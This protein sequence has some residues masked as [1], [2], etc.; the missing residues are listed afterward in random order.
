V[1]AT[2][3]SSDD[4][5]KAVAGPRSAEAE[6]AG[7]LGSS[8]WVA[9]TYFAQGLPYSLV[10]Q[11]A[12]QFFT[13]LGVPL[14]QIGLTSL[15]GLAWNLKFAWSPVVDRTSTPRRW[16]IGMQLALGAAVLGL[17]WPAARG[18]VGAVAWGLVVLAVLA[19]THDVAIDGFYLRALGKAQQASLSGLRV[20]AYRAALLVGNGALVSLGGHAGFFWAFVAAA[21]I[22]VAIAGLHALVLPARQ[23]VADDEAPQPQAGQAKPGGFLKAL[24]SFFEQPKAAYVVGF[25][26]LFRAGDAMMFAMSTPLL[27]ALGLDTTARGVV[28]GIGGTLASVAG[29]MI[30]AAIIARAG[31]KRTLLPIAAVQS[32]A[33]LLY[34]A[35]AILEPGTL[36]IVV[37]V[38]A[39]Q[40]FAGIGTAAFVVFLT[41]RCVGASRAS[42][43]AIAT[44]LMSVAG[45]TAGAASG[46][47]AEWGGFP[48]LFTLAFVAS[49]PGVILARR[50]PAE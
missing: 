18:D 40:L 4:P 3:A 12:S 42:H 10:H 1:T 49:I 45:T 32:L 25:I 28:S 43:F 24:T 6:Q 50:V 2:L 11:V 37:I 36:G 33:I 16:V 17:A 35:L 23:V 27:R 8:G 13:A 46:Y 34:V 29:S 22:L 38:L 30:G 15:Y 20:A 7:G 31:L 19:A 44:S 21:V 26:L 14:S 39:E 5:V 47:I 9:S 41:R 48:V